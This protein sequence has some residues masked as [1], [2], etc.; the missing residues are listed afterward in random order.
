MKKLVLAGILLVIAVAFSGC[1]QS[2]LQ[3]TAPVVNT[4]GMKDCGT[5]DQCI[6]NSAKIC[7]KAFS[8]MNISGE[9]QP[10]NMKMKLVVFGQENGK[11]KIQY[12]VEQVTARSDVKDSE[13]VAAVIGA[14]MQ[15]KEMTCLFPNEKLSSIE[16]IPAS[17]VK[18]YCT[19]TL[20]DLM[21]GMTG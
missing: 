16:T 4:A 5:D 15:G 8:T 11:C 20:A 9:G 17:D 21:S 13:Q 18:A 1:F 10:V 14:M 3:N 6:M 19:G 12:L 7:E 2:P